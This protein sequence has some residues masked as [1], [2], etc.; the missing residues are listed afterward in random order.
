MLRARSVL[1]TPARPLNRDG[2]KPFALLF[3]LAILLTSTVLP[4]L[5]AA[6]WRDRPWQTFE[7]ELWRTHPLTGIIWGVAEGRVLTPEDLANAVDQKRFL[8]LG[9]THDNPDHHRLQAWLVAHVKPSAVVLEMADVDQSAA[10]DAFEARPDWRPADL[11]AVLDWEKR[12]WP[13]WPLYQPIA[14]AAKDSGATIIAGNAR[15]DSVRA[16]AKQGLAALSGGD[17]V[18]LG[19]NT[20]LSPE[21]QADMNAE[22]AAS[23]CDLLPETAIPSMALAQRLRDATMADA[24]LT[25]AGRGSRALLISGSGH[26]RRDRGVPHVLGRRGV[27]ASEIAS[28]SFV[29]VDPEASTAAELVPRDAAD[30]PVVDYIWITPAASRPDMCE[31]MKKQMQGG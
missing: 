23:H 14:E 25:T 29:E 31:E 15:R 4:A 30:K 12:G 13:A 28:V 21:A 16:V 6:D 18:R 3:P 1:T 20:P 2:R 27:A 9:E 24:L 22:I 11:G 8:L 5:A 10:L 7:A 19:L 17:A 26:A